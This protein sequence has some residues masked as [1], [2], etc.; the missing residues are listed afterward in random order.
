MIRSGARFRLPVETVTQ[1]AEERAFYARRFRQGLLKSV[2]AGWN[3]GESPA[4]PVARC[5]TLSPGF[6][7]PASTQGDVR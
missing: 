4:F 7:D 1:R 6:P 3:E 2:D 5:Q